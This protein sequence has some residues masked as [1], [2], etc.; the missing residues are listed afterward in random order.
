[1]ET[2]RIKLLLII[3][4]IAAVFLSC[5]EKKAEEK[6][7]NVINVKTIEVMEV[8]QSSPINSSGILA[9]KTESKLS[10]KTGG[11][12]QNIYV[13]EGESVTKG[14]MLAKLDLSEIE[15][16]VK[17]AELGFEKA[18]RDLKRVENL[19]HDS[20]ATLENFQ[21]ATTALELAES[22]L[23]IARFNM[24]HS[25]II[26]PSAGKILRK[27]AHKNELVSSGNPV[28]IFAPS[29]EDMIVRVNLT[30]KEVIKVNLNDSAN[31]SFDAY[32][33]DVFKAKITEI[34]SAADPYSG[35]YEVELKVEPSEK[36]LISGFIARLAIFPD[37]NI[38]YLQ[39][40]V[41][42]LVDG[43]GHEG[44]LFVVESGKAYRKKVRVERIEN[45]RLIISKGIEAGESVITEGAHY[46]DENSKI[47]I[48]N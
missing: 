15:A 30:D 35:T 20:V 2:I 42:A 8:I 38:R 44:Y 22:S 33:G 45:D 5:Q 16:K 46:I 39:V 47:E 34:A 11:I 9:S 10:F 37:Q 13:G 7:E 18:K 3:L 48:V 43:R 19:Y 27:L 17:Q 12:I 31:I 4:V 40:P 26:A 23:K 29:H 32:Q 1:M 21:D 6:K 25:R 24:Q 36:K 28:F 14:R 41:E